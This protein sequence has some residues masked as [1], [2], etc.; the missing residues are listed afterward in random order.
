MHLNGRLDW[1]GRE[2]LFEAAARPI[3]PVGERRK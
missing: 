2:S 1:T 3:Q